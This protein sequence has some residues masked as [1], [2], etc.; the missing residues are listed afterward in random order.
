MAHTDVMPAEAPPAASEYVVAAAAPAARSRLVV[1]GLLIVLLV[2]AGLRFHGLNWDDSH[3]LHPDERFLAIVGNAIRVPSNPLDYFD[4]KRSTLNPYNQGFDGFA[5][6]TAPL[7]LVRWIAE[8]VGRASYDQLPSVGR[9]LSAGF[10]VGTIL[11]VFL[12]GRL[13]YGAVPGLVAAAL[14][15]TAVLHI[16][17]SHFFAVD[18]FLAFATTLALYAAYRAWLFG[19]A[20]N[21]AF[22]G[23]ALGLGVATKL[24]AA[25]LLPIVGLATFVPSPNGERRAL[26]DRVVSLALCGAVALLV[27]RV[28]EPYSFDATTPLGF[29]PNVQRFTDLDRWVKISS[30]EI[31]VPFMLQWANTPNPR[32]ALSSLVTWGFGAAAG[33]SALAGLIFAVLDLRRWPAGGRHLLL[34]AWAGINVLYFGF[35]FAKFM[36]YFLPAYPVL[37]VLAGWVLVEVS[38]PIAARAGRVLGPALRLVAPG[39]VAATLIYAVMFSAIYTRPNTRIQAS[40]WIYANI[41]SGSVLGI[42][43]WDDA[44]PLR[45]PGREQKYPDVTMALYDEDTPEKARKLAD[46]LRRSDYLILASNRLYGSIPRLPQRYPLGIAYYQ[47][48][49]SGQ[50]GFDLVA[51]FESE[52]GLFGA[53]LDSSGAQEDFTVYDHPVVL[54]F[55]KS[56]SFSGER[57]A[58]LLNGVPLDTV[59]RLKPVEASG[60]RGLLLSSDEWA[61]VGESGTWSARFSR[62]GLAASVPVPI[63]LLVAEALALATL[64]LCWWLCPGLPDRGYGLAKILGLALVAYVTWLLASVTPLPNGPGLTLVALVLVAGLSAAILRRHRVAFVA[65]LRARMAFLVA[66]EVVFLVAFGLMLLIRSLNPDLW[67]PSFGGE[68]PMD[69]AYFNAVIKSPSFPPYDPWF[70]GGYIN[71]YYYGFVLMGVLTNLSLVPPYQAYNLAVATIFALTATGAFAFGVALFAGPRGAIGRARRPWALAAGGI[72]AVSLCV[73][74]NLD[75]A[76]QL[77]EA[78]WKLGGEGIQSALPLVGGVSRALSG[79]LV[80]LFVGGSP[81]RFDFWRS[82]RFIGPEEPGPIHEFPYFTFLYGDLHAHMVSLPLQVALALVGLQLVRTTVA[83]LRPLAGPIRIERAA[84]A[85][86]VGARP[87]ALLT[88]S[89]L[90]IGSLRATNTWELPTYLGLATLSAAVALGPGRRFGWRRAGALTVGAAASL[91]ALASLLFWPFLARYELFYSGVVPIKTPTL[92]H[93]FLLVNGVLLFAVTGFLALS[94]RRAWPRVIRTE[95]IARL[96]QATAG[97]YYAAVLPMPTVASD[98]LAVGVAATALALAAGL[99]AFGRGTL[100]IIVLL[101][102]A[103]LTLAVLRH[104]SRERLWWCAMLLA[105]LGALALPE[106]VTVKGDVGRMNTVFKFWLQAWVLLSLLAG[107]SVVWVVWRIWASGRSASRMRPAADVVSAPHTDDERQ[108]RPANV[109]RESQGWTRVWLGGLLA[110]AAGAAVYPVFATPTKLA[111][112]FAPLA[113]TLDGMAY[114]DS[115]RYTDR[116]MD[117]DLPADAEAIRWMLDTIDGTPTILEG[118]APLYHWGSRFSVYTGLPTVMGWDWHQRQQRAAYPARIEERQKD[119]AAAYTSP[120]PEVAWGVIRKYGVGYVVVGSLERAYYAPGGLEKFDR[121]VGRGL[122]AAYRA[123]GVTIYRVA[124]S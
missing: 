44:L 71:Y 90:L 77:V 124:G 87:L 28:G 65:D 91:Y 110:L 25:L 29:R 115:A 39:V 69:L 63:W 78:L 13:V 73:H 60:R 75:G 4:T 98:A 62:T 82:T 16:Q 116:G 79:L 114:M 40:E 42:E 66:V 37:A 74:G 81:Q 50:L 68:K 12:L 7:F 18:T 41:P 72:S 58:G 52:P 102:T 31:E 67:H 17:L 45:L 21:F 76:A 24:S 93:Q 49:F 8:Q 34:V 1:A 9:A 84:V 92:P 55:K 5:Y 59:E 80:W 99:H 43:H 38:G 11:L 27:Y 104:R 32:Y 33:L 53:T 10:D 106:I 30:G 95:P 54:I 118:N 57:V 64:P 89:A 47:A 35:Q 56:E 111:L 103:T 85:V 109:A 107:P 14:T 61:R 15:A 70:A 51:R 88:L 108:E 86:R 20:R 3:H 96:R 100:G 36:R 123:N 119:V 113:P 2:G 101:A 97:A 19:G 48:L 112:R 105:A 117:L 22:L 120:D 83:E 26:L 6:G 23:L 46:G 121:M 122:D 94:M